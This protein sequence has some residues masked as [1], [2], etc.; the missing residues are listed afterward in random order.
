MKFSVPTAVIFSTIMVSDS[1]H[2]LPIMGLH[3]KYVVSITKNVISHTFNGRGQKH[4]DYILTT[5]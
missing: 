3:F 5:Q 1:F 2:F 4:I